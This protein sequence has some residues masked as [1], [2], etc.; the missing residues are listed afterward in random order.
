[1]ASVSYT[2]LE[3]N[4]GKKGQK[5]YI[6]DSKSASAGQT[7]LAGA[8]MRWENKGYSEDEI[9]KRIKKLRRDMMTKFEMCIRDSPMR[10]GLSQRF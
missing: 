2:H 7:L 6:I 8:L 10:E 5:I 3:E 4:K 1:M 9:R